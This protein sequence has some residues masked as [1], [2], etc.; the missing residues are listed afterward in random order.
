MD[1]RQLLADAERNME[2]SSGVGSA[3]SESREDVKVGSRVEE[4]IEIRSNISS[5]SSRGAKDTT[6]MGMRDDLPTDE[7]FA[8]MFQSEG[9]APSNVSEPRDGSKPASETETSGVK[10]P[11]LS[12][13]SSSGLAGAT[14]DSLSGAE[15]SVLDGLVANLM[16]KHETDMGALQS[17]LNL[18]RLSQSSHQDEVNVLLT[19]VA[20]A[21]LLQ[22]SSN[23]G[24]LE[25]TAKLAQAVKGMKSN[26]AMQALLD[27]ANLRTRDS[28]DQHND[29]I[30][31]MAGME[32]RHTAQIAR[33]VQNALGIKEAQEAKDEDNA[34]LTAKG[35]AILQA[36]LT[37]MTKEL[38]VA[39]KLG[40]T[41]G[42]ERD[43]LRRQEAVAGKA[44]IAELGKL[45]ALLDT[46]RREVARRD[47][48]DSRRGTSLTD[49]QKTTD[50]KEQQRLEDMLNASG[51]SNQALNADLAAL[52][53]EMM[54]MQ[55]THTG[56]LGNLQ[57][58]LDD[59]RSEPHATASKPKQNRAKSQKGTKLQSIDEGD[60]DE[61]GSQAASG[62]S[63]Q[64]SDDGGAVGDL[65]DFDDCDAE[66]DEQQARRAANILLITEL[67]KEIREAGILNKQQNDDAVAKDAEYLSKVTR[68]LAQAKLAS[69]ENATG[70]IEIARL[71]QL[72]EDRAEDSNASTTKLT[73]QLLLAQTGRGTD[74]KEHL[75]LMAAQEAAFEEQREL[76]E[77]QIAFARE[78]KRLETVR[79]DDT[80]R[81][82]VATEKRHAR[83]V[84][85]LTAKLLLSQGGCPS[86]AEAAENSVLEQL[87]VMEQD[88]NILKNE[89]EC[90]KVN[91]EGQLLTEK[92][93]HAVDM[94]RLDEAEAQ[95]AKERE[96]RTQIEEQLDR[97]NQTLKETLSAWEHEKSTFRVAPGAAASW[98]AF[99]RCPSRHESVAT[100]PQQGLRGGPALQST[101]WQIISGLRDVT[102]MIIGEDLK[103]L[104]ASKKAFTVW[105]SVALRGKT[106]GSLLSTEA[107]ADWLKQ[108]LICPMR[109]DF[110]AGSSAGF[111]IRNFG[112]AEFRG[113]DGESFDCTVICAH[114]PQE[115]QQSGGKFLMVLEPLVAKA[116]QPQWQNAAPPHGKQSRLRSRRGADSNSSVHSDDITPGDSASNVR[117]PYG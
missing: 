49:A 76:F 114:M 43:V 86:A 99:L 39:K 36:E 44:H 26:E 81:E 61:F 16:L 112:C 85:D 28:R 72:S 1:V 56:A 78:A 105:G 51:E 111:W 82:L 45:Q 102:A 41:S 15:R 84:A 98:P 67:R 37:A 89:L 95:L 53:V 93:Q 24:N 17:A 92:Q 109:L 77:G 46:S 59:A 94:G 116:E 88:R 68:M 40:K 75:T 35:K 74:N 2:D 62:I 87:R 7:T 5:V 58:L 91:L 110:G 55:A 80:K 22:K 12:S 66:T 52:R 6:G 117:G 115:Q 104:D 8:P 33:H 47:K 96:R 18:S 107:A 34:E 3:G 23:E 57:V 20:A 31:K 79:L 27:A 13:G 70:N 10:V 14:Y 29:D 103:I 9:A 19:E 113:K 69:E 63:G 42:A 100:V 48:A 32:A 21:D 4:E 30:D 38:M 108:E 90:M 83:T 50:Q 71:L 106:A 65:N 64:V 97:A 73:A 60:D 54:Q 25:L 11:S 101:V